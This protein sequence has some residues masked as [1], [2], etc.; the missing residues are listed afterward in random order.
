MRTKISILGICL[1]AFTVA[2]HADDWDRSYQVQ[3]RMQLVV[4]ADD[5]NV[6]VSNGADGNVHLHVHSQG[7]RIGPD[8]IEV[9]A[10]QQGN[11]VELTLRKHR[12]G[13][14][15]F[16]TSLEIR[17]ML[18]V[19]SDLDVH[20]RDG[21]LEISGIKG[22][23]RLRTGDGNAQVRGV[24]GSV[25]VDTGDGNLNVDGRFD[26]LS[27]RSGDGNI[28]AVARSGSVMKSGW[29]LR[30]GDGNIDIRLPESFAAD[31][32]AH[33]GDGHVHSDFSVTTSTST[34]RENDLRGRMNGGGQTLSI[35]TG[36]GTI[37]I[38]R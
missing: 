2:A 17:V 29:L 12:S 5:G 22:T 18:P 19:G 20:T 9:N 3:G 37:D 8:E 32:D 11:R 34:N 28:D 10:Q 6:I 1:L 38:R 25:E 35:R 15:F 36:D 4:D 13:L 27:A 33:T 7:W 26:V 31:L 21:N 24:D 14:H 30:T 23:H 16:S